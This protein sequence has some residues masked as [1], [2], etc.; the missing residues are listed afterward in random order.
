MIDQRLR[1]ALVLDRGAD[2]AGAQPL[3]EDQTIADA[4]AGVGPDAIGIDRAGD[5]V[6]ELHLRIANG[7]AT[8]QRRARFLQLVEAA[9]K[10]R[11]NRVAVE[12]VLRERGNRERRHRLPAHR[13]DVAERVGRGDLA[14][15]ERIVDDRREEIDR[16][17]ERWA[18]RP[19]VDTGIVRGPV[20]DQ[21][22]GI[23][24]RAADRV[25]AL[26]SSPAAS[27]LAQPAQSHELGQ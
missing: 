13:V 7:V 19:P 23:G 2:D 11:A 4:R 22:P 9:E 10:D 1:R 14:V 16:L 20:V 6:A 26:A 17:H 12:R 3:G 18:A 15:G 25:N 5:R 24:L 27:L 21:H 8:E